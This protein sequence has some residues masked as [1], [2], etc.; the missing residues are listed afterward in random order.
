MKKTII[1]C[2]FFGLVYLFPSIQWTIFD[3]FHVDLFILGL[4]N[5]ILLVPAYALFLTLWEVKKVSKNLLQGILIIHGLAI[6]GM[7]VGSF[8]GELHSALFGLT[9]IPSVAIFHPLCLLLPRLKIYRQGK[10]EPVG[11][12]NSESLRSSP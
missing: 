6:L 12:I 10:A 4:I 3:T 2:L 7:G 8:S 1:S 5:L 9:V 11:R